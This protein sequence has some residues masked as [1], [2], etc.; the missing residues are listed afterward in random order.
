MWQKSHASHG[1]LTLA[2]QRS[3]AKSHVAVGRPGSGAAGQGTGISRK[4]A[5]SRLMSE[6]LSRRKVTLKGA[7]DV[8]RAWPEVARICRALA[9][10]E[11]IG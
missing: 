5:V 1:R 3:V 6:P 9:L 7:R 11:A 8:Q 10:T 2:V 4:A